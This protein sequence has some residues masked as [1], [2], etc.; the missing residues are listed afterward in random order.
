MLLPLLTEP[1]TWNHSYNILIS[2]KAFNLFPEV[3]LLNILN[4][5]SFSLSHFWHANR[6]NT[7]LYS[8]YHWLLLVSSTELV[9][10]CLKAELRARVW[11]EPH[12]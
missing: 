9:K 11:V 8:R 2:L 1:L 6:L 10:A 7:R 3:L 4:D 5:T 12:S